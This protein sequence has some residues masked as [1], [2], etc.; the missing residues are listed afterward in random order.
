MRKAVVQSVVDITESG[1]FAADIPSLSLYGV[2]ITYVSPMHTQ[3]AGF[4]MIPTEGTEILVS[5]AE[6]EEDTWYYIG[7]IVSP[8]GSASRNQGKSTK[9]G[10][11]AGFTEME[12]RS[13]QGPKTRSLY[14]S[15]GRPEGSV[16]GNEVGKL[17]F[18][19]G[20]N[21]DK[22][23]IPKVL[24]ESALGKEISL[25]DGKTSDQI[26]IK[27]EHGDGIIISS[28]TAAKAP[29]TPTRSMFVEMHGD[30]K[31]EVKH[32]NMDLNVIKGREINIVNSSP[33]GFGGVGPDINKWGNINLESSNKDINLITGTHPV[34][35]VANI[36]LFSMGAAGAVQIQS[37]A[38]GIILQ[39]LGKLTINALGG[40]DLVSP[41]GD[42]NLQAV[43][44][45]V[46]I[47]AGTGV[48]VHTVTGDVAIDG[49][50]MIKL[51][52]LAG[53]SAPVVP[54]VIKVNSYGHPIV[55][56]SIGSPMPIP[57]MPPMM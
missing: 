31:Q 41:L 8:P 54:A 2:T 26:R 32:G 15:K 6:G 19:D 3:T 21:E 1:L 10:K 35:Q 37:G 49:G 23:P 50:P 14:Q 25:T 16:M 39:T 53:I 22:E 18:M 46:N 55:P 4:V 42:I 11:V 27:N 48:K 43:A 57:P 12:I 38:G 34:G 17:S 5:K 56:L 52:E 28:N 44:G 9:N 7:S 40:I 20:V 24:L 13:I 45:G 47:K 29:N 51:N 36:N 33:G 30:I